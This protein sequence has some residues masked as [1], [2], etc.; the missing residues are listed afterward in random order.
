MKLLKVAF[1]LSI[2]VIGFT[3]YAHTSDLSQNS[4]DAIV[5]TDV[6]HS[7]AI[8]L[9]TLTPVEGVFIVTAHGILPQQY[10]TASV[11]SGMD[12]PIAKTRKAQAVIGPQ[13]RARDGL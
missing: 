4:Q 8:E 12:A 1:M 5:L 7:V 6:D 10:I 3:G 11:A 13:H 2:L 9:H